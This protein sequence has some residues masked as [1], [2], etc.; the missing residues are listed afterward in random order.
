MQE[1]RREGDE[2]VLSMSLDELR[3]LTGALNEARNGPY[4]IPEDEWGGLVG[5]PPERASA[6]LG[7]LLTI[8]ER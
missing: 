1:V 8:L 6:L 7:Q 5:Q 2:V 3:L 4:A